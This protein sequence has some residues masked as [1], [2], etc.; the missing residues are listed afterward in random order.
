MLMT[1]L[2]AEKY[3][4]IRHPLYLL[5]LSLMMILSSLLF[6][7]LSVEY[8]QLFQKAFDAKTQLDITREIVQPLCSWHIL[9]LAF[10]LPLFTTWA[11]SQE[12]K[13]KTAL[14]YFNNTFG[15]AK[16]FLS[17]WLALASIP[18]LIMLFLGLMILTLTFQSSI[19]W[20]WVSV[21][22]LAVL[23]MS[24][25]FISIGLCLS[26]YVTQPL[27]SLTLSYLSLF[28][29]TTIEWLNPFG[30]HGAF[31]AKSLSLISHSYR[32][33]NG[34]VYS[35]DILYYILFNCIFIYFGISGVR[36]KMSHLRL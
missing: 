10:I 19:N 2:H 27:I 14:L 6:Y 25:S 35:P 9:L 29:L 7:R 5:S 18:I 30:Q 36:Y 12:Y 11:F 31:L 3:K 8:F 15:A 23:L 21:Q 17:K 34:V 16:L 32:L 22:L 4:L 28:L 20:L 24:V 33:F 26:A 1:L 13:N